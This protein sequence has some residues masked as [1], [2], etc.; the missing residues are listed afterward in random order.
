MEYQKKCQDS[1]AEVGI[2]RPA[3]ASMTP[4]QKF[5]QVS[6]LNLLT[7]SILLQTKKSLGKI[8]LTQTSRLRAPTI[9][10]EYYCRPW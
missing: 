1:L 10:F 9:C 6:V 8:T 4:Q 3:N 7:V 5:E 2:I